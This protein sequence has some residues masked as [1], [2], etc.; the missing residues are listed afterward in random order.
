MLPSLFVP[1]VFF[2]D[3]DAVDLIALT[4]LTRCLFCFRYWAIF[5]RRVM[6]SSGLKKDR[7]CD[8]VQYALGEIDTGGKI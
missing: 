7:Y 6:I 1:S 2:R 4:D 5:S 8:K 3:S